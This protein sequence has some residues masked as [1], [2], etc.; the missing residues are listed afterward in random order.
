MCPPS[1][2]S[3]ATRGGLSAFQLPAPSPGPHGGGAGSREGR[4]LLEEVLHQQ[5]YAPRLAPVTAPR[6]GLE[7]VWVSGVALSREL[8]ALSVESDACTC[9][10]LVWGGSA[11][12]WGLVPAEGGEQSA[13]LT[14]RPA[15]EWGAGGGAANKNVASG[16]HL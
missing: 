7:D 10:P 16:W 5:R 2:S 9:R 12:R 3:R 1:S 4:S 13:F 8:L 14:L 11:R 15:R 6:G